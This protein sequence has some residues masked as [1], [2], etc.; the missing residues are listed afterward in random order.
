MEIIPLNILCLIAQNLDA[1]HILRFGLACKKTSKIFSSELLWKEK[2]IQ[3]FG[4]EIELNLD[5]STWKQFYKD[6]YLEWDK[7]NSTNNAIVF[8]Y[9]LIFFI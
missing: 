2:C 9:Y 3:E 1:K 5:I 8:Y 6:G 4:S 7:A